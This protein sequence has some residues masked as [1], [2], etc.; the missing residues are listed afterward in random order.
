LRRRAP[1]QEIGARRNISTIFELK[2]V[3]ARAARKTAAAL[4][5]YAADEKKS[6]FWALRELDE[7]KTKALGIEIRTNSVKAALIDTSN[8]SFMSAGAATKLTDLSQKSLEDALQRLVEKFDWKGL[9]GC[10]ITKAVSR[11]LGVDTPS[12]SQMDREVG[13]ILTK[14]LP[15]NTVITMIHTEAGGYNELAYGD[16]QFEGSLVLICT[17]GRAFGAVLYKDGRRVRNTGINTALACEWEAELE[18]LEKQYPAAFPKTKSGSWGGVPLPAKEGEAGY[19][20]W[21]ALEALVVKYMRDISNYVKPESVLLMPTGT[22]TV[23]T[24]VFEALLKEVQAAALTFDVTPKVQLCGMAG[25]TLVKGAAVGA[26]IEQRV[27]EGINEFRKAVDSNVIMLQRLT[28]LQLRAVFDI[29][30]KNA[31]GM[32]TSAEL[33]DGLKIIGLEVTSEKMEDLLCM[34]KVDKEDCGAAID[35]A[36]FNLWWQS[37]IKQG[38]VTQITSQ[39]EWQDILEES[40]DKLVVLQV[41]FTFCRPCNAFAPKYEKLAQEYEESR[42]VKINGNENR[43]TISLCRD[44]LAVER[45]PTFV[46][47]RGGHEVH[48]H[49]GTNVDTFNEAMSVALS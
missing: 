20:A 44:E 48:R 21:K 18:A 34:G 7:T 9:V 24:E 33:A 42:F 28:P 45:T 14:M 6:E 4:T 26:V 40:R 37:R 19:E 36:H 39:E 8:G 15:K 43:S 11:G 30:D 49:T 41:G 17:L 12:F 25:G 23:Q 35:F 5:V 3:S 46:F 29:F 32:V 10:S 27:Q 31:D 22:A 38:P 16:H 1:V 2:Q 47:F 13:L